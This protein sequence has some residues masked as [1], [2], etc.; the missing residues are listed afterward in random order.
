[1]HM[2]DALLSPMVG[3]AMW[4]ATVVV[5]ARCIA[6]VRGEDDDRC[7]PLMGVLGAFVF[8]AQMV[9]FSIPGTGSSGHLGGGVLL[10][11]LLGPHAAFLVMA[12]VL[13]IQALFF[14]D[15]GLLALGCNAFNL[16][17]FAIFV[18]YP[19]VYRPI[20]GSQRTRTRVMA[21]GIAASVV[22]LAFGALAVVI[23]T[24]LSGVS[25]LPFRPFVLLMLPLHLAI[26]LVEGVVTASVVAVL[27]RE[28]PELVGQGTVSVGRLRPILI[29]IAVAAALT[30][31]VLSWFASAHPDGLEWAVARTARARPATT[32]PTSAHALLRRLQG[33]TAILPEYG[34]PGDERVRV[35]GAWPQVKGATSVSGV[36]GGGLTFGLAVVVGASIRRFRRR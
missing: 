9:N 11:I 28:R 23:E 5:S 31:G 33:R 35:A 1:M 7:V 26:G 36:V 4:G 27:Q 12:S 19:L 21:G 3:A 16:G 14:A 2:S 29:T 24:T 6:K 30:G 8:A 17:F 10:A 18:A 20:A 22:A 15:G 25:S 34:L 32:V 13:A